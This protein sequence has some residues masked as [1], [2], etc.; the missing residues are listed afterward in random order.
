L[1]NV[2]HQLAICL[3]GGKPDVHLYFSCNQGIPSAFT[4]IDLY[5]DPCPING[6]D[7]PQTSQTILELDHKVII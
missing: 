2:V 5:V 4:D 7:H 6:N 1:E 3:S